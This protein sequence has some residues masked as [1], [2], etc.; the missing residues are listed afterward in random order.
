MDPAFRAYTCI[1][2]TC[3]AVFYI[4]LLHVKHFLK[5]ENLSTDPS[6]APP[7]PPTGLEHILLDSQEAFRD[8]AFTA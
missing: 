2:W 7:P 1:C 6:S 3:Y 5:V 8:P 4:L